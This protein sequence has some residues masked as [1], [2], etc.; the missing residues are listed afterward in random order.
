M[1]YRGNNCIDA[2]CVRLEQNVGTGQLTGG[3]LTLLRQGS[4]VHPF[5]F[6]QCDDVSLGHRSLPFLV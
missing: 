1:E 5:R 6:G 3:N 2:P 4:E